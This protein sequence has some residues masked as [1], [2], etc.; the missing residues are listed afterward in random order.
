MD[1]RDKL[2]KLRHALARSREENKKKKKGK[3]EEE[4][5]NFETSNKRVNC[6]PKKKTSCGIFREK[7]KDLEEKVGSTKVDVRN[8]GNGRTTD[9]SPEK[10]ETKENKEHVY[11]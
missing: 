2:E 4:E 5:K 6:N 10:T 1:G 11:E 8:I 9:V 7:E 3:K